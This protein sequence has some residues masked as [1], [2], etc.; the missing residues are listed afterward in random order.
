[1]G[2]TFERLYP[3]V[4]EGKRQQAVK[5]EVRSMRKAREK[6]HPDFKDWTDEQIEGA[7]NS[8]V[9]AAPSQFTRYVAKS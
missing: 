1:M 8:I 6:G 5:R 9:N 4:D 3:V 7:A 2:A